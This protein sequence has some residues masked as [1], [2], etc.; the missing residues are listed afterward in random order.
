MARVFV[1]WIFLWGCATLLMTSCSTKRKTIVLQQGRGALIEPT[2]LVDDTAPRLD[3]LLA[4][5]SVVAQ[6]GKATPLPAASSGLTP[7]QQAWNM[8]LEGNNRQYDYTAVSHQEARRH[9]FVL[10]QHTVQLSL[11]KPICTLHLANTKVS[12]HNV[13]GRDSR[14]GQILNDYM[15]RWHEGIGKWGDITDIISV[16]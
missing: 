8:F 12:S 4:V 3:T 14:V 9:Q 16:S 7:E 2:P 1:R 10:L 6:A 13:I 15:I 11:T 5:Q